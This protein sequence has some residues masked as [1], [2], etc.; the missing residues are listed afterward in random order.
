[1]ETQAE[2]VNM[3]EK[4]AAQAEDNVFASAG[5]QSVAE[6]PERHTYDAGEDKITGGQPGESSPAFSFGDVEDLEYV[7]KQPLRENVLHGDRP[8]AQAASTRASSNAQRLRFTSGNTWRRKDAGAGATKGGA[9]GG[10][11]QPTGKAPLCRSRHWA[12]VAVLP[13]LPTPHCLLL[14][15]FRAR[16]GLKNETEAE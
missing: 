6:V 14:L 13:S 8:A 12:M 2:L 9:H 3:V 15:G 1:M 10:Y 4:L 5:E 11:R 7:A 16:F